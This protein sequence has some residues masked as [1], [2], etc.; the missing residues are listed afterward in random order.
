[1]LDAVADN[2]NGYRAGQG[3]SL[4]ALTKCRIPK[5]ILQYF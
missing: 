4:P 5:L 2:T 3:A 1:M